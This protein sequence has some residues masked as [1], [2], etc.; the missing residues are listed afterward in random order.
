MPPAKISCLF[1]GRSAPA[2][3]AITQTICIESVGQENV[4]Q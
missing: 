3:W 4:K 1:G 2:V